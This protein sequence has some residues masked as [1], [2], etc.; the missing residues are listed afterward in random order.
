MRTQH[1]AVDTLDVVREP[2]I[3]RVFL[4]PN[5]LQVDLA[6]AP[7]AQFGARAPTFRLVF[8]DAAEPAHIPPPSARELIGYG[9]LS[10]SMR[11][12]PS[13]GNG[14]GRPST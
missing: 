10:R 9:W 3:Y 14:R 6:F 5:T 4:L 7:A 8:G 12:H 1:D 2:W 13:P 11:G